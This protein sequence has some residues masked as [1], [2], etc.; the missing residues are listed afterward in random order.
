VVILIIVVATI[1]KEIEVVILIIE[2]AIKKEIEVVIKEGDVEED[3]NIRIEKTTK[4]KIKEKTRE[5]HKKKVNK[6]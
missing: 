3:I 4:N 1:K 5:P 6:H 2:V